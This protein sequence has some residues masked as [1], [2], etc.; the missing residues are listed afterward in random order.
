MTEGTTIE[1][2]DYAG[3]RVLDVSLLP[4]SAWD[5]RAPQWWGNTLLIL[6]ESTTI[7]LLLVAY[8][9]IRRNFGEWPPVQSNTVPPLYHP[10]PDLLASTIDLVLIVLSCI[11]MYLTDMAA[12][13]KDRKGVTIGLWLMF[14]VTLVLIGLR[15]WE[16]FG[17]HF[18]WDE[19]AYG[20]IVWTILGT[21]LTYLLATSAEFLIMVLWV[22][23]HGIDKKHGLDVTLAGGYWY[24]AA[25]TW[26]AIYAVVYWG[27]RVL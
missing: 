6:I 7:L 5:S 27:A 12:R 10:V 15:F 21:H 11:P 13:R 17:V 8:F 2:I 20:S 4:D 26:V 23:R 19:N 3:R 1:R 22:M 24:W 18:R 16:F 25:G 9:Y 14:A